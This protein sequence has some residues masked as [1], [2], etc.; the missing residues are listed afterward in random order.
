[1]LVKIFRKF[2]FC[3]LDIF[4]YIFLA[5][6]ESH[7]SSMK[8]CR[9]EYRSIM[10]NPTDFPPDWKFKL[11]ARGAFFT[12]KN[13]VPKNVPAKFFRVWIERL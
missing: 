2:D 10:M 1:M 7:T 4:F 5:I 12:E 9:T 8:L 11:A 6:N 3:V 13:L